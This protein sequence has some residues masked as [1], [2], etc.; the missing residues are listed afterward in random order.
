[1]FGQCNSRGIV[2]VEMRCGRT[3]PYGTL[4]GQHNSLG[5]FPNGHPLREDL[6]L[7]DGSADI[8]LLLMIRKPGQV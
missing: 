8:N 4:S 7:R 1:M 2:R 6:P 3:C 5:I